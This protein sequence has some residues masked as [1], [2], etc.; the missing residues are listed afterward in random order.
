M[1]WLLFVMQ[2][3]F[4]GDAQVNNACYESVMDAERQTGIGNSK[5]V[6]CAKEK[7]KS[8]GGYI[9]RYAKQDE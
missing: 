2:L 5:I 6:R 4:I 3:T 8:A 7:R 9:W 1:R